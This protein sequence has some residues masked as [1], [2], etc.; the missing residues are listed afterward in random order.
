[1]RSPG[2]LIADVERAIRSANLEADVSACVH[3]DRKNRK[4]AKSQNRNRKSE[5]GNRKSQY[6]PRDC[7]FILP[8]GA[9]PIDLLG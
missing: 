9:S 8:Q 7:E 5:I 3:S 6:G 4:I 1:M 2:K